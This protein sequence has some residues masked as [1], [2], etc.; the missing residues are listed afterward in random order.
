MYGL[1][2]QAFLHCGLWP[3]P[4]I[5]FLHFQ[6]H[7][8]IV[9]GNFDDP[10]P[11]PFPFPPFT[12]APPRKLKHATMS[13]T[14]A[15]GTRVANHGATEEAAKAAQTPT[16]WQQQNTGGASSGSPGPD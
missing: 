12:V 10:F 15:T 14:E 2:D 11:F 6:L 7:Y 13:L 9:A 16:Q 5:N 8:Y 3:I 1:E 4:T